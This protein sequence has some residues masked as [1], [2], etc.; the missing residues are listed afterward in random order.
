MM[1]GTTNIKFYHSV[2]LQDPSLR[3]SHTSEFRTSLCVTDSIN[4]A[5]M[6]LELASELYNQYCGLRKLVKALWK[7]RYSF[8]DRSIFFRI[9]WVF[10]NID[11][12][13]FK[14]SLYET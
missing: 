3:V 7:V 14:H 12:G 13:V 11:L 9:H 6:I 10:Q 8:N 4:F 2:S 5:N 1:H